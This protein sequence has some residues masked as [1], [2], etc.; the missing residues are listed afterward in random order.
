MDKLKCEIMDITPTMAQEWLDKN[1][2][3][4]KLNTTRVRLY[5]KAMERGEWY[6]INQGIGLDKEGNLLDGQ[7][8]LA[9]VIEANKT[10]KM[11]VV[12]G[13]EK[14]AQIVI[15]TASVRTPADL[16]KLS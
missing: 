10:V 2:H 6:T 9:A 8:R 14:A 1:V 16:L 5:A 3:N 15:D 4:R 11:V 13:L 12:T 7:N